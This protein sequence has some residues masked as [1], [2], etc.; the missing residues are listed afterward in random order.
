MRS[1]TKIGKQIAPRQPLAASIASAPFTASRVL[2]I[3]LRPDEPLK[4]PIPRR[5]LTFQSP[6][7]WSVTHWNIR[8]WS[9]VRC[10][11]KG[12]VSITR[13]RTPSK[14]SMLVYPQPTQRC[15]ARLVTGAQSI[16]P[17]FCVVGPDV[18][19][20]FP[21][22][23]LPSTT[24]GLAAI[25]QPIKKTARVA[26]KAI[27]NM[28]P[29][30]LSLFTG[31]GAGH[32]RCSRAKVNPTYLPAPRAT[33]NLLLAV[34]FSR[35][36]GEG[37]A[38]DICWPESLLRN[39][40]KIS[41]RRENY[42]SRKA[43]EAARFIGARNSEGSQRNLWRGDSIRGP[44]SSA[45][46]YPEGENANGGREGRFRER[47]NGLYDLD[48]HRPIAGEHCGSC[49]GRRDLNPLLGGVILRFTALELR[50]RGA[51][52][53]GCS[54]YI[55]LNEGSGK[56]GRA[57]RDLNPHTP[58]FQGG[59]LRP[60]DAP[61]Q[62]SAFNRRSPYI[63]LNAG[64]PDRN[65]TCI[66]RFGGP[67]LYPLSYGRKA[68]YFDRGSGLAIYC[69]VNRKSGRRTSAACRSSVRQ[70]RASAQSCRTPAGYGA[71]QTQPRSGVGASCSSYGTSLY[72]PA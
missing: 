49:S 18:T 68:T 34:L 40:S 37:I 19:K 21:S 60:I 15:K 67:V 51:S 42:G 22:A 50:P 52:L 27:R 36:P 25:E 53:S 41:K 8:S 65:R 61:A 31:I 10:P 59:H 23:R 66:S 72:A 12:S 71:Q 38:R 11:V 44:R 20:T 28:F 48:V 62:G 7:G 32:H 17:G 29:P 33:Q 14:A 3:P 56:L 57:G 43:S 64:A 5:R 24:N 46:A 26:G 13:L 6:R 9:Q 63:R 55:H 58:P 39:H 16:S 69:A 70:H 30:R 2:R 1:K 47:L 35:L 4:P 54:P 45:E